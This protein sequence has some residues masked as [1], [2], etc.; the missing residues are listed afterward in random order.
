M[1]RG[2]QNESGSGAA[3]PS[4]SPSR[5]RLEDVGLFLMFLW[6][7]I[8]HRKELIAWIEEQGD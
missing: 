2:G 8:W 6:I 5:S 3:S 7:L 1:V 4:K